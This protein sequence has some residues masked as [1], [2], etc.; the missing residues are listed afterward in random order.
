[1]SDELQQ[2]S[3]IDGDNLGVA[4]V[5]N[6]VSGSKRKKSVSDEVESPVPKV[7]KVSVASSTS[8]GLPFANMK[9][10]ITGV[11]ESICDGS[12][13]AAEDMIM[14]YGG[15]V[16]KSISGVTTYLV[17]GSTL[18]D[19]RPVHESSKYRSA[20]EKKVLYWVCVCV[21]VLQLPCAVIS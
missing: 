6:A 13:E 1:M 16:A 9:I 20:I 21:L 5:K 12:R 10:A 11:L 18:E 4:E 15:K 8:K 7:F 3:P 19:G 2:S 14:K 17:A